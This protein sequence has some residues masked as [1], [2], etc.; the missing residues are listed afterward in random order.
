M[1]AMIT[2]E[3]KKSCVV[4]VLRFLCGIKHV[5]GRKKKWAQQ[6][7]E[8]WTSRTQSENHTT[9]PHEKFSILCYIKQNSQY[10]QSVPLSEVWNIVLRN[11]RIIHFC[12]ANW[13]L[14]YSTAGTLEM[15]TSDSIQL[16]LI[17]TRCTND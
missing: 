13:N 10:I 12:H 8:L 1:E 3:Q 16:I 9:R 14:K 6:G 17:A 11:L 2:M 7:I 15:G 4:L 5:G